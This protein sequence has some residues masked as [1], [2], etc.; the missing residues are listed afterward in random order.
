MTK[1]HLK[2]KSNLPKFHIIKINK[3]D[4]IK[5]KNEK[6]ISIIILSWK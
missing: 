6:I 1:R 4:K 2:Q 3:N 5:N